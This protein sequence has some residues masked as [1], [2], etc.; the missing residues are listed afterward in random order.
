MRE[1]SSDFGYDGGNMETRHGKLSD[2]LKQ[3]LATLP[4]SH[5]VL[6]TKLN[7]VLNDFKIENID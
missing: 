5:E 2:S 3:H 4:T 6:N 7:I 1:I